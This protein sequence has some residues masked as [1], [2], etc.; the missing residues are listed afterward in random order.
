GGTVAVRRDDGVAGGLGPGGAAGH[1][2]PG[3]GGRSGPAVGDRAGAGLYLA[4][5]HRVRAGA[6]GEG[7]AAAPDR[8][9]ALRMKS[10][11]PAAA[12]YVAEWRHHVLHASRAYWI[13]QALLMGGY[14]AFSI[15]VLLGL[16]PVGDA[17]PRHAGQVALR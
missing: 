7:I 5:R 8:R 10:P 4:D 3:H 9:A 11:P 6:G 2:D 1:G 12:G 14:L 17:L 13:A 16:S 15:V